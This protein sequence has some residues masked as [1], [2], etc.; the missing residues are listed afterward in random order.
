M[1]GSNRARTFE[2]EKKG[3]GLPQ[4]FFSKSDRTLSGRRGRQG[5]ACGLG[6]SAGLKAPR[7]FIQDR[8]A[9]SLPRP[10]GETVGNGGTAGLYLFFAS[11]KTAAEPPLPLFSHFPP[12]FFIHL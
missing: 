8:G 12:F 5:L 1:L 2:R 10:T 9:A 6:H 3:R 11:K 4:S 7:A